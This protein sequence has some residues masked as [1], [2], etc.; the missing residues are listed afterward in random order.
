MNAAQ[1][2]TAALAL[3]GVEEGA[4]QGH[5]DFRWRKK[6]I[7]SLAAD[8]SFA[9]VKLPLDAQAARVAAQPTVYEPFAG[10]WGRSGCTKIHLAVARVSEVKAALKAAW[11]HAG[12]S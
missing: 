2:R 10:A 6:I 8:G 7:A 1:F 5:P 4:H 9:M 12:G 3:S 11:E